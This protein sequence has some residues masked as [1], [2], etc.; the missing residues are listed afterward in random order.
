MVK[1]GS[2]FD[3]EW[4]RL[5]GRP[6]G[7]GRPRFTRRGVTYT[8]DVTRDWEESAAVRLVSAWAAPPAD[9]PVCVEVIQ[10]EPRPKRF[11]GPPYRH[12]CPSGSRHPDLDNCIKITVDAC[13]TA[14]VFENDRQVT[15]IHAVKVWA[16][17]DE[18]PCVEV[19]VTPIPAHDPGVMWGTR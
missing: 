18:A 13:Q 10:V 15:Q 8:D 5:D 9:G 16:A 19:R 11:K 1:R 17:A 7:K 6:V 3:G 4:V 2:L 14:A 12:P